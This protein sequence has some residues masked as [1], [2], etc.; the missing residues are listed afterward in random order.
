ML[1]REEQ[2]KL[3][4]TEFEPCDV[5]ESRNLLVVE[6]HF[7][8]VVSVAIP[9]LRICIIV[10]RLDVMIYLHLLYS[11]LFPENLLFVHF[12]CISNISSVKVCWLALLLL[13]I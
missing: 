6:V 2:G 9:E 4:T 8:L 12:R 7:T 1:N 10:T 3:A 13:Q 5:G 11:F